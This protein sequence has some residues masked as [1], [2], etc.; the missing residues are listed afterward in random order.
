MVILGGETKENANPLYD[1]SIWAYVVLLL[2]PLAISA[3]NLAMRKGKK[4]NDNVVSCY[5][6]LS[7]LVFFLSFCL[8]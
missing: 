6:A 1:P 3:G 2:N 8:V 7:L 5:M 4:L